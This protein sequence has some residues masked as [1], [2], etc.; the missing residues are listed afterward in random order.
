MVRANPL[1]DSNLVLLTRLGITLGPESQIGAGIGGAKTPRFA[2]FA[3]SA[4]GTSG[5]I[6]GIGVGQNV[7]V[8]VTVN[9]QN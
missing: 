3:T 9:T 2:R 1:A 7:T 6:V 5:G 4:L 8:P